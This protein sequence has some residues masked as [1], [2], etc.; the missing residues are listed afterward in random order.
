MLEGQEVL[1]KPHIIVDVTVDKKMGVSEDLARH[2]G[3]RLGE[4]DSQIHKNPE[5]SAAAVLEVGEEA[6]RETSNIDDL[7]TNVR[8]LSVEP[9]D[10]V[11]EYFTRRYDGHSTFDDATEDSIASNPEHR[12]LV[13]DSL[14]KSAIHIQTS[15]MSSK[16][17]P[18]AEAPTARDLVRI[19][20]LSLY[21]GRVVSFNEQQR[22][23]AQESRGALQQA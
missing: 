9:N 6:T 4:L 14:S 7:E 15:V 21:I 8:S 18:N 22:L 19:S 17:R 5:A 10:L 13:K 23:L 1:N 2:I 12:G 20:R 11:R 16:Q 3:G